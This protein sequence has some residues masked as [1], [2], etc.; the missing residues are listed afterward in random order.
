MAAVAQQREA[1]TSANT[2]AALGLRRAA[3]RGMLTSP[4]IETEEQKELRDELVSELQS[5]GQSMAKL[6]SRNQVE[7]CAKLDVLGEE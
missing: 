4:L 5:V 1:D 6:T 3:L 2:V 7:L